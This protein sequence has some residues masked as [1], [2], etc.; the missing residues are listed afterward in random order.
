MRGTLDIRL[1]DTA[2]AALPCVNGFT[3]AK[4]LF[5]GMLAVGTFQTQAIKRTK[6]AV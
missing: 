2:A 4:R 6:S 1:K 3:T 5:A